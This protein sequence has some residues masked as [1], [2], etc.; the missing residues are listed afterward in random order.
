VGVAGK[1]ALTSLGT[2]L[3][4]VPKGEK[5]KIVIKTEINKKQ[6]SKLVFNN[7]QISS[8][9]SGTHAKDSISNQVTFE[10]HVNHV[11]RRKS[12]GTCSVKT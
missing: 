8:T 6:K 3:L 10:Q 9:S 1:T 5:K 2:D 12:L 7:T 4:H 11:E